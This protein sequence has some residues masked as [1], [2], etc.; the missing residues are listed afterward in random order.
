ML[1]KW[2]KGVKFQLCGIQDILEEEETS[3]NEAEKQN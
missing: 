2:W 3:G 1:I